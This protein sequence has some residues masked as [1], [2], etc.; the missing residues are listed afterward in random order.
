MNKKIDDIDKKIVNLLL[1]N[2]D[3]TNREISLK[4]GI[5]LGT[6]N[7]RI[8]DLKK[9]G[10]IKK[11]T[12]NVD[13]EKLGYSI[14]VLIGV[15]IRKGGFFGIAKKLSAHPSVFLTIDMTGE[16]DAEIL[17]R[18]QTTRQLDKFIKE[19]QQDPDVDHT[20]TRLI[21][22]MYREKEIK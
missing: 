2:G 9:R 5:A 17:A 8:H 6:V 22:N 13:Y 3:I 11:K 19:M 14:Q 10:I 7:K 16:Y 4:C 15:K 18:F 20:R 12:I 21:L 1:D